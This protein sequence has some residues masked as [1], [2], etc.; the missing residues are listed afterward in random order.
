[1]FLAH[2]PALAQEQVRFQGG[3][4]ITDSNGADNCPDYDPR[5]DNGLARYREPIRGTDN[6][7]HTT[8]TLYS[9][10]STRG[11]AKEGRF[12]GAFRPVDTIYTGDGFG[13]DN[14][15]GEEN[16]PELRV[17]EIHRVPHA[18]QTA[19]TTD[20]INMVVQVRGYDF[21]P[22]CRVTIDV[23]LFRRID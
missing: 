15:G 8:L 20:F 1:V 19:A 7:N 11:F 9:Q 21:M 6:P 2:T 22:N 23:T 13:P 12:G 16:P 5:G 10:R 4:Q 18:D 17:L 14:S 3:W